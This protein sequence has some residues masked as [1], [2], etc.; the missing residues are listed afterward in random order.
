MVLGK[1]NTR[2]CPVSFIAALM[3]ANSYCGNFLQVRIP[4]VSGTELDLVASIV[5]LQ[6][7]VII[8]IKLPKSSIFPVRVVEGWIIW[9]FLSLVVE[10]AGYC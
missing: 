6:K 3:R 10:I 1:S 9:S 7:E 5:K 2:V 8:V 4:A